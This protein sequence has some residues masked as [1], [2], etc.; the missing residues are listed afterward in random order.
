[1][2]DTDSKNYED[3]EGRSNGTQGGGFGHSEKHQGMEAPRG[4]SGEDRVPRPHEEALGS[5]DGRNGGGIDGR[6]GQSLARNRV[7][8]SGMMDGIGM[9]E[10][11]WIYA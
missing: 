2:R 3:G 8:G 9:E 7:I 5:A 4:K 6:K 10:G 11:V 1:M